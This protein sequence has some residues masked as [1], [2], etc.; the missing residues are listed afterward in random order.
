MLLGLTLGSRLVRE[1]GVKLRGQDSNLRPRGY[2]AVPG[3]P[4]TLS[5]GTESRVAQRVTSDKY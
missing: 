1:P 4:Q 3:S 5:N 2:E